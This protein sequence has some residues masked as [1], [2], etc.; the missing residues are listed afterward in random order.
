MRVCIRRPKKKACIYL[1]W[2]MAWGATCTYKEVRGPGEER[3]ER[4]SI[5]IGLLF[6]L[7]SCLKKSQSRERYESDERTYSN[8]KWR[9]ILPLFERSKTTSAGRQRWRSHSDA[10]T[11]N[12][13]TNICICC[14]LHSSTG[15]EK[16]RGEGISYYRLWETHVEW[17]TTTWPLGDC[18]SIFPSTDI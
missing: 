3:K 5:V 8:G 1:S 2:H 16:K 13:T 9:R 14:I 6:P 15:E 7:L 10:H 18:I 12:N 17:Y 11:G 4:P